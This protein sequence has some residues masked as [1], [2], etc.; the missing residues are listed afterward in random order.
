MS[1]ETPLPRAGAGRDTQSGKAFTDAAALNSSKVKCH[2]CT[3]CTKTKVKTILTTSLNAIT[4]L[5]AT[6][7]FQAYLS[8]ARVGVSNL[9]HHWECR[10]GN[11]QKHIRGTIMNL[12]S[13]L[14]TNS[15]WKVKCFGFEG[16][17]ANE[18]TDKTK[19]HQF[20]KHSSGLITFAWH[21]LSVFDNVSRKQ[22]LR[23]NKSTDSV[24]EAYCLWCCPGRMLMIVVCKY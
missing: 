17:K 6:R 3:P 13:A 24:T 10:H 4:V 18:K 19:N 2:Y 23:P 12:A 15:E 7:P 5:H 9:H 21:G 22:V 11:L 14:T 1:L 8:H 20:W 16:Y